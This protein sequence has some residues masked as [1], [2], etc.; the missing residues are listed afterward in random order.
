MAEHSGKQRDEPAGRE[1]RSLDELV[2]TSI[3][4]QQRAQELAARLADLLARSADCVDPPNG[5]KESQRA[6]RKAED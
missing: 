2:R 6:P 5:A 1:L 3:D 4:L